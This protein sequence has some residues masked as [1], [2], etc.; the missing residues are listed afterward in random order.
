MKFVVDKSGLNYGTQHLFYDSSQVK[1]VNIFQDEVAETAGG[2]GIDSIGGV[3]VNE[4][5]E[6][7]LILTIWDL[8][9]SGDGVG[10]D[11]GG[12]VRVSI[13]IG[14]KFERIGLD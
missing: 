1:V 3:G 10:S 13:G 6:M 7:E 14:E 9:E 8:D 12:P 5:E 2:S 11:L 4:V